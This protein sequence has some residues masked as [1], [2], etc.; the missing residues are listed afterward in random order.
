M[1]DIPNSQIV[2]VRISE[3]NST[4]TVRSPRYSTFLHEHVHICDRI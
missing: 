3:V 1:S 4:V 2:W